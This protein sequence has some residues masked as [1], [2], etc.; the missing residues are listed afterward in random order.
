MRPSI[1][2]P[3]CPISAG[4]HLKSHVATTF[5]LEYLY[6]RVNSFVFLDV[7]IRYICDLS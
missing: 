4:D 5:C 3:I 2:T 7:H 1:A 6:Y